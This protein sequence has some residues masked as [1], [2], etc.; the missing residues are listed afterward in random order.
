[1]KKIG[2]FVD[3]WMSG[4]IESYLVSNYESMDLSNLEIKII[5]TRKFSDIYDERLKKLGI[6][7]IELLKEG[8]DSE[9]N[10]TYKSRGPFKRVIAEEKFDVIHLNIYNGVSLGYSKLASDLG[11][12]HIIAHSHNSMIGNVRL[13]KLKIAAH[14]LG[15]RRYQKYVTDF[16]ACSDLA[17]R[18]LFSA[19]HE[20]DVLL[21]NN[22]IKTD[23]FR[24]D[25][26]KRR[27]F[28]KKHAIADGT[29]VLGNIGRLNNQKNQFFLIE[30]ADQL[31]HRNIPYRLFIA[32]EGELRKKLDEKIKELNL[33][34]YITLIG[35]TSDTPSFYSGIDL[36]LLPSLFEGNP[37]VGI[38]AQC[39]GVKCLFSEKITKQL[40]IVKRSEFLSIDSVND[41]I[42]AIQQTDLY[43]IQR[44]AVHLT[45]K[46]K[47]F[48]IKDTSYEMNKRL[49]A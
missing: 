11:V 39:S 47:K 13:K 24:Y 49:L 16:W 40:K 21:M 46:E 29:L 42:E 35:T 4:G 9:L 22:G 30:L 41:W 8:K 10:R 15:K 44:E 12:K 20:E 33:E 32:G 2:V 38:E 18:W 28:R 17:G 14:Y 31:R 5:T 27:L 48:D 36:F 43:S 45:V 6:E 37:I 23:K 3:R 19:K 7:I 34:A 1:M 25:K 26:N